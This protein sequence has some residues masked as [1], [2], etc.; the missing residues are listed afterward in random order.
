MICIVFSVKLYGTCS[1][2]VTVNEQRCK[3]SEDMLF[4]RKIWYLES[5]FKKALSGSTSNA[6]ND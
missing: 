5:V 6:Y 1:M 4:G 2:Y 3:S